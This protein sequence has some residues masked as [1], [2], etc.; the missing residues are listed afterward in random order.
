MFLW[1][2][3]ECPAVEGAAGLRDRLLEVRWNKQQVE[4]YLV[5]SIKNLKKRHGYERE[6]FTPMHHLSGG[7]FWIKIFC[8]NVLK[9]SFLMMLNNTELLVF[10]LNTSV[11]LNNPK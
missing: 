9:S 1:L 8:P 11:C 10:I 6:N 3:V 4:F 7:I 2:G 5:I